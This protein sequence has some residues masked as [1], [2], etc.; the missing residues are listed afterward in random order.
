MIEF[1][2]FVTFLRES[3]YHLNKPDL[4]YDALTIER[5]VAFITTRCKRPEPLVNLVL[6]LKRIGDSFAAGLNSGIFNVPTDTEKVFRSLNK[7]SCVPRFVRS[8]TRCVFDDDGRLLPLP[9]RDSIIW[10]LQLFKLV[11]RVNHPITKSL[12]AEKA[13]ADFVVEQQQNRIVKSDVQDSCRTIW[14]YILRG[15]KPRLSFPGPGAVSNRKSTYIPTLCLTDESGNP[16]IDA[17]VSECYDNYFGNRNLTGTF[18]I[19]SSRIAQHIAGV[20]LRSGTHIQPTVYKPVIHQTVSLVTVPKNVLV[21]RP[22][23]VSE[24]PANVQILASLRETIFDCFARVGLRPSVNIYDQTMSH[25]C[26]NGL[27]MMLDLHGGSGNF[28]AEDFEKSLP[29]KVHKIF[30]PL[31]EV[32]TNSSV[33]LKLRTLLMG[34]PASVAILTGSL[35]VGNVLGRVLY[36]RK[37][38]LMCNDTLAGAAARASDYWFLLRWSPIAE[39]EIRAA[40]FDISATDRHVGDDVCLLHEHADATCWV[41]DGFRV[42]VNVKKSSS[43]GSLYQETCGMNL[44]NQSGTLTHFRL[45]RAPNTGQKYGDILQAIS[46]LQECHTSLGPILTKTFASVYHEDFNFA[47]SFDSNDLGSPY[48]EICLGPPRRI[49]PIVNVARVCID[50]TLSYTFHGAGLPNDGTHT[51]RCSSE[52]TSQRS[53]STYDQS[54][55]SVVFHRVNQHNSRSQRRKLRSLRD[56]IISL[57]GVPLRDREGS[58]MQLQRVTRI[59]AATKWLAKKIVGLT[60]GGKVSFDFDKFLSLGSA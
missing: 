60:P 7:H 4:L 32:R 51:E 29:E 28:L 20:F 22:I 37:V 55:G 15:W 38:A 8:V 44:I 11:S 47:Q 9:D 59:Q 49:T 6:H 10:C 26:L 57:N 2:T 36:N 35:C 58:F 13:I 50:D 3:A 39:D 40:I 56:R 12:S 46:I 30:M 16:D 34:N 43:P 5:R 23:T 48:A 14:E 42:R 1:K 54:K 53:I 31:R 17:F 24:S 21:D 18:A 52:F 25:K 19:S 33:P 27:Y 41:Y 45:H